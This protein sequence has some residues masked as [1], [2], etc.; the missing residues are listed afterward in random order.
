MTVPSPTLAD[1]GCGGAL[2]RIRQPAPVLAFHPNFMKPIQTAG[3]FLALLALIAFAAGCASNNTLLDRENAAIGAGF[4]IIKPT[5]PGQEAILQKLPLDKVTL[6]HYGGKPY[7]ILPDAVH[8]RAFVG[9]PKQFLAYQKFRQSQQNN[10][11][12][13]VA[14]AVPVQ[15]VEV[16]SMNWGDWDG[17][18]PLGPLGVMGEP[19]W[20][21]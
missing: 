13:Y 18:G 19:G 1:E 10:A 15:V 21:Y 17:W 12:S 20:Y 2:I 6:I 16:D 5:K 9:G 14:P 11:E 4:K 7:Y 3:R 8:N